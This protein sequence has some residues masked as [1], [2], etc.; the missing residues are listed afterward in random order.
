MRLPFQFFDLVIGEL[1]QDRRAAVGH[2]SAA[3]RDLD[4][5]IDRLRQVGEERDHFGGGLEIMLRREPPAGLLLVDIGAFGNAD[6][7]VMR[8]IHFRFREVDI[9][10]R[11]ER[12][13]HGIGHLHKPAFRGSLRFGLPVLARMAL[14]FDVKPVLERSRKALHQRLRRR[15]L[16]FLQELTHRPVRATGQT[17][18]PA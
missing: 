11:H 6:Q 1:G 15:D 12:Q 5:V 7:R 8:L 3:A 16:P 17:D 14:Q 10:G 2:E 9:I 13:P 4:S 18:E